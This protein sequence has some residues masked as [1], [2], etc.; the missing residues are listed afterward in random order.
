MCCGVPVIAAVTSSLTEVG[1]EAC[2]YFAPNDVPSLV[3]HL[4]NLA[5]LDVR[6]SIIKKGLARAES[7]KADIIAQ[8]MAKVVGI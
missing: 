1:G 3:S 7:F 2:L 8:Q 4:D 6:S 5:D